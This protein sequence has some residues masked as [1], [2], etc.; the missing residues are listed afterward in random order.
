M[1]FNTDIFGFSIDEE[2]MEVLTHSM[3]D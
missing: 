2:D 1:F 3:K